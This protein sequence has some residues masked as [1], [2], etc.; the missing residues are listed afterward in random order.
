MKK[1]F[2]ESNGVYREETAVAIGNINKIIECLEKK[3]LIENEN[4]CKSENR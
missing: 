4:S 3:V 2:I 1:I